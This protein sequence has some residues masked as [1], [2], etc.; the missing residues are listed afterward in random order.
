MPGSGANKNKYEYFGFLE[1]SFA[2]KSKVLIRRH[3]SIRRA[4]KRGHFAFNL[5]ENFLRLF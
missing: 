1:I 4:A 3:S 2:E 5:K